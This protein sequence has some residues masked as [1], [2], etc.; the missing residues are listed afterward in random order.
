MVKGLG[1]KAHSSEIWIKVFS[2]EFIRQGSGVNVQGSGFK[3]QSLVDHG[4]DIKDN[5]LGAR[6]YS[7]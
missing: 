3:T 1:F 5:G 4:F 2:S 7:L 6:V